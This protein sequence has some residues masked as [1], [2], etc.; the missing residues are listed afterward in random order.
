MVSFVFEFIHRFWRDSDVITSN[1]MSYSKR[2]SYLV[3]IM[4]FFAES[5]LVQ[6][7]MQLFNSWTTPPLPSA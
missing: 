1:V 2:M 5:L 7:L 3:K 4:L 6:D